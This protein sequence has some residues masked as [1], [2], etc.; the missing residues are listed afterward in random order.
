MTEKRTITVTIDADDLFRLRNAAKNYTVPI[1]MADF[2]ERIHE[3]YHDARYKG[4]A[5]EA[6]RGIYWQGRP[7]K[8]ENE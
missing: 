5:G 6:G 7:E 8:E 2:V 4:L 3:A 1:A